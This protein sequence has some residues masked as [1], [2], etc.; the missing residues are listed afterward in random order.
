MKKLLAALL[1]V[2]CIAHAEFLNG[3]Q[4]YQR[5]TSTDTGDKFYALGYVVGAYDMGVH[6]FFCPKT[7]SGITAG[8]VQDIVKQY[9]AD[10]PGLRQQSADRMVRDALKR[11]WP[12]SNQNGTRL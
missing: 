5:M 3:N 9:M 4:L 12:C 8:Q 11:V 2:P 1:M 6:V 7:E 10:N